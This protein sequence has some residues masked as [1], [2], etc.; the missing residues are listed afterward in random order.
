MKKQ[1]KIKCPICESE[2]VHQ[3]GDIY[4]C[5]VC[6]NFFFDEKQCSELKKVIAAQL[7]SQEKTEKG[8]LRRSLLIKIAANSINNDDVINCC[9]DLLKLDP[10]DIV[11]KYFDKFCKRTDHVT[12]AE[13]I[14]FLKSLSTKKIDINDEKL[15]MT[16]IVSHVEDD[17]KEVISELLQKRGI[18]SEYTELLN[19]AYKHNFVTRLSDKIISIIFPNARDVNE[20]IFEDLKSSTDKKEAQSKTSAQ[21]EC[22]NIFK[23]HLKQI[24]MSRKGNISNNEHQ[25]VVKTIKE[26]N[27]EILKQLKKQLND[28]ELKKI[29]AK[30]SSNPGFISIPSDVEE[31]GDRQYRENKTMKIVLIPKSIKRIGKQAFSNCLALEKVIFEADSQ[32]KIIDEEAFCNCESLK[33]ITIPRS[34]TKIEEDAFLNCDSLKRVNYGGAISQWATIDFAN[35][36]ANPL[37]IDKAKLYIDDV[38]QDNIELEEIY[39]IRKY[40]FCGC[41]FIKTIT[42]PNSIISIE[43]GAFANCS[44]L[45]QVNYKG[46]I[47][48]WACTYFANEEANPLSNGKAKLYIKG[49]VQETIVLKEIDE[50]ENYA[51][52]NCNF[53]KRVTIL[54]SVTSIGEGAFFGCTKLQ[55]VTFG[56]NS[57]L[58]NIGWDAFCGCSSLKRVNYNGTISKWASIDFDNKEANPL[59][60]KKLY[61]DGK[62]FQEENIVLDRIAKIGS[63]AFAGCDFIKTIT[64]PRSVTSIGVGA[65][66]DCN[67][68]ERVNYKGTISQWAS[69]DFVTEGSNPLNNHAKL[70][71]NNKLQENIVLKGIDKV[72]ANAFFSYKFIKTVTIK[73]GV[74]SIENEAFAYCE[75]LKNVTLPSTITSIDYLTFFNCTSLKSIHIPNSVTNIGSGAFGACKQLQSITFEPNSKLESIR[76]G[77][78]RRCDSLINVIIPKSVTNIEAK[79]FCECSSLTNITIPS[80]VTNIGKDAFS[81]CISLTIYCEASSK[82]S[83]WDKDWNSSDSLVYWGIN[84]NNFIEKDGIQY[85]VIDE[86]AAVIKYI[87]TATNVEIPATIEINEKTYDVTNIRQYSFFECSSL[88]SITIPSSVINIGNFAFYNCSSLEN[89]IIP[90]S[91][92]SIERCVFSECTKLQS[93]TFA[94][95]SRLESID[96]NA[97]SSC[98]S[99]TSIAIPDSVR[100]IGEGVFEKCTSLEALT[101]PFMDKALD[102]YFEMF[103]SIPKSLKTITILGGTIIPADA[104]CYCDTLTTINIPNSI[105]TIQDQAF[106]DC[107][108]LEKV[109]Y[110]GTISQWVNIYFDDDFANPL[111]MKK[112]YID[113]KLFQEENIVLEEIDM[114]GTGAFAGCD[115]IKTVTI[116]SSVTKIRTSAF[117]NCTQLQS[118]RFEDNS[119]LISIGKYAF[120]GCKALTNITIPSSVKKIGACAFKE[121]SSLTSFNIP[122]SVKKI[123]EYAFF[124]CNSLTIYCEISSRPSGWDINWN[125]S[126]ITV[127][128]G[129][130]WHYDQNGVPRLNN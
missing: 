65:F 44:S 42:I 94:P 107:D 96:E 86:K 33:N 129:N 71:I 89:I 82:P 66:L 54:N 101:L 98:S 64:I 10:E 97:F 50:I 80:S 43:E 32:L 51:F 34:V 38:L 61:I 95:N 102:A 41:G 79:A 21:S 93:V 108:S 122:E 103:E 85:V 119:K 111:A 24:K 59:A 106:K 87:G 104:F 83:K 92:K 36:E 117:E 27:E 81:I 130:Q 12:Q 52:Y 67:S 74:T 91:V 35:E 29:Y 69:I 31:I 125:S 4:V 75:S 112:L 100:N 126:D 60:M 110:N 128:W 88:T 46:T 48:N 120:R 16:F 77:A 13:Y 39:E 58:E 28:N 11:A 114:I 8:N 56:A 40:A 90:S 105:N 23:E 124:I 55:S 9:D 2:K 47:S 118:V 68:L 57:K 20:N 78:F 123:E 37:S 30:Y 25:N 19:D 17:T 49:A 72:A 84:E 73:E 53:I 5:D 99:L 121:C 45:K 18:L 127:Y 76:C 3:E 1:I 70:Y 113:G 6:G 109:V 116:P 63:S 7:N 22:E 62:L 15:I 14:E 26:Q 115:F